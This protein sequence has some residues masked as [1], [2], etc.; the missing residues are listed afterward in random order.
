M[1]RTDH[2]STQTR[3]ASHEECFAPTPVRLHEAAYDES[4]RRPD[5]RRR[6][7]DRKRSAAHAF[8][9]I[10]GENGRRDRGIRGLPDPNHGAGS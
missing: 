7:V 2:A 4:Q 1:C 9:E 8:G 5:R 6:E 3:R 10:V